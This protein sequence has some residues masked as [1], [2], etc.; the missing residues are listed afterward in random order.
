MWINERTLFFSKIIMNKR[1]ENSFWWYDG[2]RLRLHAAARL[3]NILWASSLYR[4]LTNFLFKFRNI[5][6]MKN[7]VGWKQFKI[8]WKKEC[9]PHFRLKLRYFDLLKIFFSGWLL[10]PLQRKPCN[11]E[12]INFVSICRRQFSLT[13]SVMGWEK[14]VWMSNVCVCV[15]VCV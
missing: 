7:Q 12:K 9:S 5:I 1:P 10:L 8:Y 11:R 4:V 6:I 3:Y 13:Y 2:L 15:C 14:K